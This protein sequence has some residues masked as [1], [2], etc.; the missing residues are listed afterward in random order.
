VT[1]P[2]NSDLFTF[3][4]TNAIRN[5]G[6]GPR[7]VVRGHR[8]PSDRLSS[9]TAFLKTDPSKKS[10][11]VQLDKCEFGQDFLIDIPL[12]GEINPGEIFDIVIV[13]KNSSDETS[14]DLSCTC[15]QTDLRLLIGAGYHVD[16]VWWNTQRDYT[17]VG[18]RQGESVNTFITLNRQYFELLERVPE[19]KCTIENVPA[20]HPTFLMDPDLHRKISL[21]I[22]EGRLEIIGSYDE[23]QTTLVGC[24]LMCR[25]ISYGLAFAKLL[26]GG[27][28]PERLGLAQW[29]VFGHDPVWPALAE[30]FGLKWTTFC[31]GLYHGDHLEPGE[32]LFPSEFRWIAPDGTSHLTHYMSRH[33][34]SGWEFSWCSMRDAEIPVLDRFE[35]LLVT[36]SGNTVLLPCYGDFAEPFDGMI[37]FVRDW[38]SKY[39]SPKILYGTQDDYLAPVETEIAEGKKWLPPISRDMNPAFSGCNI[40]YADTKIAQKHI[41]SLLRD[42]EYW[43]TL[44]WLM[45][46]E[47]PKNAVDRAWRILIYNAHHDAVTGSESDQVYLDLVALW[48]E[49]RDIASDLCTKI[50]Q[51]FTSHAQLEK[52]R[53][54]NIGF[55]NSLS[56]TRSGIFEFETDLLNPGIQYYM[57]DILDTRVPVVKSAGKYFV[58]TENLYADGNLTFCLERSSD[59]PIAETVD[60]G[61]TIENDIFKLEIKT[62]S[63][64]Y[65]GISSLVHKETGTEFQS[66]DLPSNDLVIYPEY[67]GMNMAPWLLQP[68]GERLHHNSAEISVARKRLPGIETLE[69]SSRFENCT[70][71]R[72]LT[73]KEND[74]FVDC[75]TSISGYSDTDKMFRAEFNLNPEILKGTRPIAQTSGGVIGRPFGQLGDFQKI[76]YMGTWPV[77][78][79]GG[80]GRVLAVK[81]NINGKK[82]K[83]NLGVC[84]IIIPSDPDPELC[85]LVDR[86]VPLLAKAG[87]TSVVTKDNGRRSGD[88]LKDSSVPDF[89]ISLGKENI[90]S[91]NF[92][93]RVGEKTAWFDDGDGCPVI[94]LNNDMASVIDS[95][96]RDLEV[97]PDLISLDGP[98]HVDENTISSGNYYTD[99][100]GC[101]ILVKGTP[102]LLVLEDKTISLGLFRSASASPSGGWVDNSPVRMPDGSYF[103]HEHWTHKF[104]YRLMPHLEM[105]RDSEVNYRALEF[106]HPVQV[107]VTEPVDAKWSSGGMMLHIMSKN[108]FVQSARPS[109]DSDDF[110]ANRDSIPPADRNKIKLHVRDINGRST[111]VEFYP[112]GGQVGYKTDFNQSDEAQNDSLTDGGGITLSPWEISGVNYIFSG[113]GEFP[114]FSQY[115]E[116]YDLNSPT[117]PGVLLP[118]R[119]WRSSL[120]P[121]EWGLKPVFIKFTDRKIETDSP[122]PFKSKFMVVNNTDEQVTVSD[123]E[124][125]APESVTFANSIPREINLPP[126]G[127]TEFELEFTSEISGVKGYL[128]AILKGPDL[129]RTIASC[130][131]NIAPDLPAPVEINVPAHIVVGNDRVTMTVNLKNLLDQE[132]EGFLEIITPY[133]AWELLDSDQIR[134]PVV[135]PPKGTTEISY[136]FKKSSDIIPGTYWAVLKWHAFEEQAYSKSIRV[137]IPDENGIHIQPEQGISLPWNRVKLSAKFSVYSKD[138]IEPKCTV[139]TDQNPE[140]VKINLNRKPEPCINLRKI[141][142]IPS[143]DILDSQTDFKFVTDIN[144][145]GVNFSFENILKPTLGQSLGS[146]IILKSLDVSDSTAIWTD[147]LQ[148]NDLELH[149][150]KSEGSEAEQTINI[151]TFFGHDDTNL[152]IMLKLPWRMGANPFKKRNIIRADSIQLA[153]FP[154]RLAEIG[155]AI[156]S[157][158]PYSWTNYEIM[159]APRPVSP[160]IEYDF[161]DK[162][163]VF[164]TSIPWSNIYLDH[165]PAYLPFNLVV[166]APGPDGNRAGAWIH[167]SGTA[168]RVTSDGVKFALL[169]LSNPQ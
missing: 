96:E 94:V 137:V 44:A 23:P 66:P 8:N 154:S 99:N 91:E 157:D 163:T 86:L 19:F 108:T 158:G 57:T 105:W 139:K 10:V 141:E 30:K 97:R 78:T 144:V 155:L 101:A 126:R 16:P 120:G 59:K 165:K 55:F 134:K 82:L 115:F 102:D 106:N 107:V 51:E 87:V 167:A 143:H 124:L 5:S 21:W 114:S 26:C 113:A 64:W 34:T 135:L 140:H 85:S 25:S 138:K 13:I 36:A 1:D 123:I 65:G 74:P 146:K 159:D 37:E 90:F 131:L 58:R 43:S 100:G 136:T 162:V 118:A 29:D 11:V 17:E 14:I 104:E 42:A 38:N 32:N 45:G 33:Y 133:E 41:E 117:K 53:E 62:E 152:Y 145:G 49:A 98:A 132:I 84:E 76:K 112:L 6:D 89:R 77:D 75:V 151:P 142:I 27:D 68:T 15:P 88:W 83:R 24:E 18:S 56:W 39:L 71:I 67:P 129:V 70:V 153:F 72:T 35:R 122:G 164:R 7:L 92:I 79:W 128:G 93:D 103:Q 60:H 9:L 116:N 119:Y 80:L 110:V 61:L 40:S 148:R 50:F 81:L 109:N 166:Y 149:W 161:I 130:P 150:K 73:L 2:F 12:P 69:I 3:T 54:A 48:R 47:Y 46:A 127:F 111:D 169:N 52:P 147:N 31:R 95:W 160:P 28:T 156:T 22:K 63:P 20:L 168:F 121:I 125:R 4:P